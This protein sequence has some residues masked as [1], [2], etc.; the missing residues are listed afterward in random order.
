MSQPPRPDA[1]ILVIDS[2]P[3]TLIATA[4]VLD[5]QGYACVCARTPEAAEKGASQ[6]SLDAVVM[7]VG[8]DAEAALMLVE[9]LRAATGSAD[10]PVL[11]IADACWA[12]LQHRCEAMPGVRCLFKP[13][14]PNA[15]LDLVQHSLWLPPLLATHRRRGARPQRPGWVTL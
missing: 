13:I 10:L 2:S 14:D 7:D 5:S 1:T 11:L 8:D 9:R 3:I 6:E 12:G 4:G 15:L